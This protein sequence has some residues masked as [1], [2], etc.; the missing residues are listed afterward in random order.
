[1]AVLTA[2]LLATVVAGFCLVTWKWQEASDRADAET[3]AKVAAQQA[4]ERSQQLAFTAQLWR[5]VGLID[6]DPALA[7]KALED[8]EACPDER[9]DLPGAITSA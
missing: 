3:K 2:L 1:M 7:V 4:L 9:R 6:S 8:E 5:A